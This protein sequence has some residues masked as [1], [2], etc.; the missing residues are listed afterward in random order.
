MSFAIRFRGRA[1]AVFGALLALVLIP[2]AALACTCIE[3]PFDKEYEGTDYVFTA[4]ALA[5]EPSTYP[6]H[7]TVTFRVFAIW[8]GHDYEEVIDVLLPADEGSC[9]MTITP[10]TDYLVWAD[11]YDHA[12]PRYTQSCSRTRILN[13]SDPIFEQLGPPLSTPSVARTWGMLKSV[14][15]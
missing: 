8:K 13:P 14:Y 5:S 11:Y 15:R 1:V 2:G 7:I 9:G 10:G 4:R 6:D 3:Q 12:Y